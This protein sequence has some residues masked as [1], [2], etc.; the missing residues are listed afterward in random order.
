MDSA[1]QEK[2]KSIIETC[3]KKSDCIILVYDISNRSSFYECKN[4]YCEEIKKRCKINIK[5]M[6]IGNKKD[7]ETERQVSFKEA[8]DFALLNNYIYM[9]TS[10][11]L[12]ENVFE[13]F[14]KIIEITE[15]DIR[16][17]QLILLENTSNK[18]TKTKKKGCCE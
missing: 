5:V 7:L 6:L 3:Y 2:F 16:K 10:C 13:A 9:E 1:G 14:E 17:R 11:L 8:N 18:K 15:E 4:Y 12:N